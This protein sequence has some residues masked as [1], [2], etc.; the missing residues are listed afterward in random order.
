MASV[1][2]GEEKLTEVRDGQWG[3]AWRRLKWPSEHCF[4]KQKWGKKDNKATA[5]AANRE[6]CIITASK[7]QQG[8]EELQKLLTKLKTKP[9]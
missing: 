7:A 9:Q 4:K 1:P 8:W 3:H 5:F 2:E 6:P